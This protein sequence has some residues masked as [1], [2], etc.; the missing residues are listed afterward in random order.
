M[1]WHG[2]MHIEIPGYVERH[3][4]VVAL[5]AEQRVRWNQLYQRDGFIPA[6]LHFQ[7]EQP[8]A[9]SP[10]LERHITPDERLDRVMADH[11]LSA[12]WPEI[13]EYCVWPR[14]PVLL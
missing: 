10:P 5:S 8:A 11:M 6:T 12:M 9:W 4:D 7:P 3:E 1:T 2:N 13:V 14:L